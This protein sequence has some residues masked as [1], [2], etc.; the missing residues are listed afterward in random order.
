M[1]NNVFIESKLIKIKEIFKVDC[2]RENVFTVIEIKGSD[3]AKL[4][5]GDK[6][7]NQ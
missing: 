4:N 7:R 5:C 6:S 3:I 1:I 2:M